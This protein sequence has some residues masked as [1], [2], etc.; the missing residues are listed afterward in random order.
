[1]HQAAVPE[2][3]RPVYRSPHDS[4]L[5][6]LALLLVIGF[7]TTTFA[8]YF[9]S[10]NE[11]RESIIDTELP[12][13]SDNVYSEIQ[14]DLIQPIVISTVM[15]HDTFLRDWVLGGETDVRKITHYLHEISLQYGALTAFFISDK[16]HHYYQTDRLLKTIS[17]ANVHDHW[18][19]DLRSQVEPYVVEVD[20]DEANRSRLTIFINSRVL[21]YD[22]TLIGV[23]GIGINVKSIRTMIDSYK[24]RFDRDVYFVGEDGKVVLTG[25]GGGPWGEHPSDGLGNQAELLHHLLTNGRPTASEN[26]EYRANGSRHFVNLR[27]LPELHWYLFVDKSESGP[28]AGI[29]CA[30]YTN[31]MV[32]GATIVVALLLTTLVL[33][34]YRAQIHAAE[35]ERYG[36]LSSLAHDIRSPHSSVL[37]LIALQRDASTHLPAPEFFSRIEG[38]M[39]RASDLANDFVQLARAETQ[40]YVLERHNIGE[41]LVDAIDEIAPRAQHKQIVVSHAVTEDVDV[42]LVLADRTLLMRAIVNLLDNAIKYSPAGSRVDSYVRRS[43]NRIE[44]GVRD[45]GY[46]IAEEAQ[47]RLFRRFERFRIAGQPE[48]YGTGLGL[49]FVKT[50]VLH[51]GGSIR[52]E[53][54]PGRG[55]TMEILLPA[56]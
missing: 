18:Y 8:S 21:A 1:M 49:V 13:T 11:I 36:A 28:L 52:V 29:T 43:G 9:A 19:F 53:S 38:Y 30:L 33:R 47:S 54:A 46:G 16:T 48:E 6:F 7:V 23:T 12:L 56:A 45:Y 34:R 31:L 14:R 4:V 25:S 51:H 22:G 20:T 41:V 27:Y 32:C 44:C 10:R 3:A 15:A 42:C 26:F 40:H 17:T 37:A 55:T 50:V 2:I 39:R 5:A 24:K 35:N